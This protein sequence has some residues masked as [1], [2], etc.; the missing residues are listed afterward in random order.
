MPSEE[1]SRKSVRQVPKARLS[2]LAEREYYVHVADSPD[3]KFKVS[4]SKKPQG[5][6]RTTMPGALSLKA[7]RPWERA[8]RL[9]RVH[10]QLSRRTMKMEVN[11]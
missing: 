5:T 10:S 8:A 11:G 6:L 3:S 2:P 7:P 4:G 1:P 9:L